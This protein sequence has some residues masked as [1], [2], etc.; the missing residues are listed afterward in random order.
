M[1]VDDFEPW[2]SFVSATLT[3]EPN[4]QIVCEVADAVGAI[5]EA[6]KV[7]PSLI[8]LDIGLPIL[9]GI[10]AAHQIPKSR[11]DQE[12]CSCLSRPTRI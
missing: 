7:Q 11:R 9:N 10:E 6:N 1:I 12:Y 8:L 4:L 2:R 3:K 5:G